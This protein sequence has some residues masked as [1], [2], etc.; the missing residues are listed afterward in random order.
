MEIIR[1]LAALLALPA[2]AAA[3]NLDELFL[4]DQA[5]LTGGSVI[6]AGSEPG[7]AVYNPAGLAAIDRPTLNLD[8]SAYAARYYHIPKLV[9]VALPDGDGSIQLDTS[10]FFS[11]PSSLVYGAKLDGGFSAALGV[12]THNQLDALSVNTTVFHGTVPATGEAYTIEEGAELDLRLKTYSFGPAIGWR[13][14]PWLRLGLGA[15]GDYQRISQV[16][17]FTNDYYKDASAF[18]TDPSG[19]ISLY[20]WRLNS[21]TEQRLG[22]SAYSLEGDAGAQI[23]LPAHWT[24]GL[25]FHSPKFR[26]YQAIDA[27][28]VFD[29]N[30]TTQVAAA[31]P[32]GLLLHLN[33]NGN[34]V[35]HPYTWQDP[36]RG[37]MGLCK[38]LDNGYVSAECDFSD[39][40]DERGRGMLFNY[41][42][43][44]MQRLGEHWSYGGGAYTDLKPVGT[45]INSFGATAVDFYGATLGLRHVHDYVSRDLGQPASAEKGMRMST[46]LA[47]SYVHG[48][49]EYGGVKADP[50]K[51][52][53]LLPVASSPF[54]SDEFSAHLGGGFAF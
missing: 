32:A 26:I 52:I 41:R 35:E 45:A 28:T 5:A 21:R 1:L 10:S 44:F 54:I 20:G 40:P 4:D 27:I 12:F 36:Y 13:A 3:G 38:K 16:N 23:D 37:Y 24:L 2:A 14:A 50:S 29:G 43:G 22:V 49:G 34:V 42:L 31:F 53:A 17:R 19:R 30:A 33:L 46:T 39:L 9:R 15:F 25:A 18:Y 51:P 47:L 7:S 6:A 48:Y 8:A 11:T